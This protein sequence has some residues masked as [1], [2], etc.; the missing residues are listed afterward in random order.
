MKDLILIIDMQNVYGK[1][2]PWECV[3]MERTA[4]NIL[5][6]LDC[7]EDAVFTAFISPV[8]PRGAW[9]EYCRVNKEIDE[10]SHA[11]EIMSVFQ[12]YLSSRRLFYKST[13]S[14]LLVPELRE[15]ASAYDR[16][17]ITGV[18][19]ECCVLSTVFSCIDEG[20]PF[21]YISDAVSGLSDRS[22]AE[23]AAIISY[24]EPVHGVTMTTDEYLRE[25]KIGDSVKK[26]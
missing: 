14:S 11:G 25:K 7:G 21:V 23:S 8:S 22:E 2:M 9:K 13:Y 1:G 18:V 3:N 26:M 19:A 15:L 4:G 6:L 24:M 5:R 16:V 12:P 17:V 20:F 10:D